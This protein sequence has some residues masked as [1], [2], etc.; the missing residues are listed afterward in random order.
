MCAHV[1]GNSSYSCKFCPATDSR[2][3]STS[4][5]FL[6]LNADPISTFSTFTYPTDSGSAQLT[7]E[8]IDGSELDIDVDFSTE[9]LVPSQIG[10]EIPQVVDGSNG[11]DTFCQAK[12]LQSVGACVDSTSAFVCKDGFCWLRDTRTSKQ[13]NGTTMYVSTPGDAQFIRTTGKLRW[14]QG[15]TGKK[16]I[17]IP[18][19][20]QRDVSSFL[21]LDERF[22]QI[23][24]PNGQVNG[25]TPGKV[26]PYLYYR[27]TISRNKEGLTAFKI[28]EARLFFIGEG[29]NS[30][31]SNSIIQPTCSYRCSHSLTVESSTLVACLLR[32]E[33]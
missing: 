16:P 22:N 30:L 29:N 18:I 1:F 3:I 13:A 27:W 15:E 10:I 21:S 2:T 25:I 6:T 19:L 31:A 11:T 17:T 33:G 5:G 23:C 24:T 26:N 7:V 8:R 9:L 4:T 12:S 28:Y 20:S 32:S 14:R